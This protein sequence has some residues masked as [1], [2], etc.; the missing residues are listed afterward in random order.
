M[1]GVLIRR[2]NADTQ[3]DTRDA[4]DQRNNHVK[5][6]QEGVCLQA[7]EGGPRG[8]QPYWH[9]DLGLPA[10]RAVRKLISVV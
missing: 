1:T 4:C 10:S 2:G 5:R 9:L 8:N 6:Q 7:E 3:R